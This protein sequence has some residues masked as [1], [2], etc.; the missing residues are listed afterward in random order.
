MEE[1]IRFYERYF[2]RKWSR[3]L[4]IKQQAFPDLYGDETW[5]DIKGLR[6]RTHYLATRHAGFQSAEEYFEGYS[7]ADHRLEPLRVPSTILTSADDPVVPVKDFEDLPENP[8]LELIISRYGGH[9]GF[10]KNWKLES[11]AED[12]IAERFLQSGK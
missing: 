5:Y 8:C 12:L 7:I 2:E 4:R 3:S 6:E 10:L 9:C 1:G 11:M